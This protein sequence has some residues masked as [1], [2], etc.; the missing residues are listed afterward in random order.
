M[1]MFVA[2]CSMAVVFALGGCTTKNEMVDKETEVALSE[3]PETALSA[4]KGAVEGFVPTE[5]ELEEEDGK[6]WYELEGTADGKVYE[7][8]VT[9]DGKILEVE[10]EDD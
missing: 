6:L 1:R 3:V 9:K 10:E 7:I 4:A 2:A 5:A 8:E